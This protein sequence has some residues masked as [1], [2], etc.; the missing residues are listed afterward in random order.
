MVQDCEET[1][2]S[3][4]RDI[5]SGLLKATLKT[6]EGQGNICYNIRLNI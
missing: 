4:K 5:D 1:V 6:E 2:T 3:L